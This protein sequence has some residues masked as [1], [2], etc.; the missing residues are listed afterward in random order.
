MVFDTESHNFF[1]LSQL[2]TKGRDNAGN[3]KRGVIT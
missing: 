3:E 2:I 1:V